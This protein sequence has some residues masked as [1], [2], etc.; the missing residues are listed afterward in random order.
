MPDDLKPGDGWFDDTL[1]DAALDDWTLKFHHE[2]SDAPICM[3]NDFFNAP[4]DGD[5]EIIQEFT[6]SRMP[7]TRGDFVPSDSM[8]PLSG[9]S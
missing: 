4:R 7:I 9:T 6:P 1:E 3:L 5:N 2:L 8:L